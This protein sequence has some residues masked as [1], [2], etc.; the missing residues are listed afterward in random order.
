MAAFSDQAGA[1][2]G[3]MRNRRG[4][5][6]TWTQELSRLALPA[7]PWTTEDLLRAYVEQVR[8]RKLILSRDPKMAFPGGPSGMWMPT[9]ES[10]FIWAHPTVPSVQYQ[11]VLGHELGHM[12]N[13]DEPDR[14]DLDALVRLLREVCSGSTGLLAS[15]LASAGVKCRTD[16]TGLDDRER[17]A[18]QFGYF[19]ETWMTKNGP[20]G[21]TLLENN[22]RASLET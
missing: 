20:R 11:H 5:K 12:V 1:W 7:S 13:G 16:G 14:L 19:A 10:D 8:G 2:M 18:E 22:M 21:V 6:G 3:V 15:A 4:R 17:T 9:P